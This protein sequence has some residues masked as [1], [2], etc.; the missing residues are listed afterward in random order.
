MDA[1][2]DV[3][4]IGSGFGGSVSALRLTEKGYRVGILEAGRRYR[5]GDFATTNWDVRRFIWGPRFG[6]YGIQRLDLLS[7]VLVLSGAGVGGGSLVYANTLYEPHE[8]FYTDRQWADITDWETELA[9]FYATAQRM[10]GVTEARADTPADDVM[11][12]VALELGVAET[13]HP[14]QIGV[15]LGEP[16]VEVA[17]PY[18]G[19]AGPRRAGCTSIGACMIG[20]NQNAKNTLDKNYL[21]LAEQAGADVHADSE[22]IDVEQLAGGR[23]MISTRRPGPRSGRA[24]N[25]FFADQVIFSAGALGTTRLLLALA[26][27]GR[28]PAASPQIGQLVRTNSEVLLGATARDTSVDY[29]HGVAI[30]SSIHP[31]PHTH[32]EPVR[33][34]KGSSVMGLLG[35]LLTDGG[36]GMPR[37]LRYIVN[38]VRHPIRWLRSMSVHRWAERSV[39]LLVMQSYD[40]SLQLFRKRGVFGTRV[41]SR[42]GHGEP[43]PTYIPIANEAAKIA[44]RA[45]NGDPMSSINEVL[46]NRP[47]TAHI[48]GGAPVGSDPSSGVID[49]YHRVFGHPT[50]HVVDGAAVGANLGVNPSLTITAMSERAMAMW[51]NKGEPDTR[52]SPDSAY[53]AVPSVRPHFPTVDPGVLGVDPWA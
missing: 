49:P 50:L 46:L 35:T 36:P 32:I 16:G 3:V 30:T 19:G 12:E 34:P 52:P 21:Y 24:K 2:Y 45:M 39:I 6:M 18:F 29:S 53:R 28:L 25:V 10:L 9:P 5:T 20:C 40:N 17:D 43:N 4:V 31:E 13:F 47:T 1:S 48:L 11:R 8:A 26:E 41:V 37:P 38:M 33:Y 44:A 22:V 42:Q 7:D 23:W 51:P 14:T 27:K 15:F